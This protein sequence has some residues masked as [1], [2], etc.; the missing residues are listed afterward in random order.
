MAIA[1]G[2]CMT[3]EVGLSGEIRPVTRLEQRIL[4]AQKLGMTDILVPR[5]NLKGIDTSK[6]TIK[7]HEVSKVEEAFRALFA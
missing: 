2:W 5:G 6:L 3:G 4:E 7:I 1:N